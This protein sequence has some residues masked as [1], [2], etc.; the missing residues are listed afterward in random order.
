MLPKAPAKPQPDTISSDALTSR[1]DKFLATRGLAPLAPQAPLAPRAPAVAAEPE[2]FVCEEDVRL[3]VLG[4]RK[5]LIGDRTI[6][7]PAARDAGDAAKVFIYA[8]WPT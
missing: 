5:L 4:G 7:T 2:K 8:G 3:A 1:I 6:V